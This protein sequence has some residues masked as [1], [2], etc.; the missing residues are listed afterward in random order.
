MRSQ[1]CPLKYVVEA[2]VGANH[3]A[4]RSGRAWEAIAAFDSQA[5]ATRY[6]DACGAT[7]AADL[8]R[9]SLRTGLSWVVI[10]SAGR[11]VEQATQLLHPQ[12]PQAVKASTKPAVSA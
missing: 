4:Q 1:Y 3:A 6:A 11:S 2:V 9:V 8:Y 7:G 5:I 10:H 12:P